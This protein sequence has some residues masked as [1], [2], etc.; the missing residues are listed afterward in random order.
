MFPCNPNRG[1]ISQKH[2]LEMSLVNLASSIRFEELLDVNSLIMEL[3]FLAPRWTASR[4]DLLSSCLL[5]VLCSLILIFKAN[6]LSPVIAAM[7]LQQAMA[8][9][10]LSKQL[11][12]LRAKSHQARIDPLRTTAHVQKKSPFWVSN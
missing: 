7:A 12:I 1:N 6:L 2:L 3:F 5:L 4:M 9:G 8:V 11:G 10:I